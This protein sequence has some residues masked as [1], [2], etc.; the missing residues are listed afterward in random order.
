[1]VENGRRTFTL[2]EARKALPLVRK[3]AS[4]LQV[5]VD[6]LTKLPGGTSFLYGASPID[7]LPTGLQPKASELHEEIESLAAELQEIGAELKGFQPVL[8]DFLSWKD[9]EMVYLCWAEGETD[10]GYW[11]GLEEGFR[12]RHPI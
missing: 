2:D 3:I 10:I 4:D 8:V 1:M 9:E 12:G 11:H 7:G 5:A 6:T